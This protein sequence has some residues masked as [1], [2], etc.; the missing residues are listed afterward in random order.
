LV[1]QCMQ[2]AGQCSGEIR[3]TS[4]LLHPP[5]LDEAGL[6]SAL[7]WYAD[8]FTKRS[9]IAVNLALPE[10]PRRFSAEVELSLFRVVQEA[11]TN[12]H[13]HSES[14]TASIRFS[15]NDSQIDLEIADAGRGI[16]PEKLRLFREG[17]SNFG[18]GIAGMRERIRQ[19][20]GELI[21]ESTG[22]GASVRVRLPIGA[23]VGK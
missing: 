14:P 9:N 20:G 17:H 11:L 19:L 23:S 1:D 7:R 6:A 18:V 8:G 21:I 16:G 4:Y 12:I 13:R 2:L 5:L 10:K 22:H 3:T 15:V